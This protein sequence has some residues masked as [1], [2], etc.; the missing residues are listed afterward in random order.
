VLI[1]VIGLASWTSQAVAYCPV[2]VPMYHGFD[3]YFA[4]A[5]AQGPVSAFAYQVSN[6]ISVNT[7]FEII[8]TNLGPNAV[9]ISTDWANGGIVGCP[10]TPAGNQRVVIL[11]QANDGKGLIVSLSGANPSLGYTPKLGF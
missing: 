2:S 8:A 7:G 9:Q 11:V 3:S 1:L 6:P 4:C 5:N 10:V